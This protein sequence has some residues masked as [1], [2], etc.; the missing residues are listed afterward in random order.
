MSER[1]FFISDLHLDASRPHV[2]TALKTFLD[3]RRDAAALYILGD[4]FEFWIGDDDDTA[5]AV[6]VARLLH[7]YQQAGPDLYFMHGNRDFLLGESFMDKVGGQLLPDPSVVEIDGQKL[8]LMHGDSLCTRDVD[9]QAFRSLA[10]DPNWQAEI[11]SKS[12]E[13][14]REL[15]QQLRKTS[16]DAGSRKADDI[17]DVTKEEVDATMASTGCGTLIHGHTH[18]PA[19][20]AE[21]EGNR[22]VLGDWDHSGWYL[23]LENGAIE[24]IEFDINQ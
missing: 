7:D 23:K 6:D 18:R 4:L 16:R 21:T 24:L 8:L 22:W 14:R 19:K 12:L 10:R 11:L 1:H 9:Y 15:A 2:T 5:I 13:T 20:H 17:M 3:E